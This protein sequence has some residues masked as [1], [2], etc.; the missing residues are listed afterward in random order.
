MSS[1]ISGNISELRIVLNQARSKKGYTQQKL[2]VI[3]GVSQGY[4]AALLAGRKQ[5]PSAKIL[6]RL[7]AGLDIQLDVLFG[8]CGIKREHSPRP[9]VLGIAGPSAAGKTWF[10]IKFREKYPDLASVISIDGYYKDDAKVSSMSCRYDNPDSVK[11]DY[12]LAD[13]ISLKNG[14]EVVIPIYDYEKNGQ[15]GTE[16]IL[17]TP[18]IILEG[19]VLFHNQ[20]LRQELDIKIW[21]EADEYIRL[22]RRLLRDCEERGRTVG[23]VIARYDSDVRPGYE[24]FIKPLINHSDIVVMNNKND[25]DEIPLAVDAVVAYVR[26][27]PFFMAAG[28]VTSS[29][30]GHNEQHI[31]VS[32]DPGE[33][34]VQKVVETVPRPLDNRYA[35]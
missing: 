5:N 19:H 10:A 16:T 23:E 34:E 31:T 24:R 22:G 8:I 7:A 30:S 17:P 2:A 11:F 14:K 28:A 35:S 18:I 4:I 27:Q 9:V 32:I 3:V 6:Q 12:L 33:V 15:R 21:V 26:V 1:N 20:R 29:G 13:I 25:K